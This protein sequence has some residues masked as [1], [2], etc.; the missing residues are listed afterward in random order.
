MDTESAFM[1]GMMNQHRTQMVFDWIKAAQIIRDEKPSHV[2]AGLAGDWEWTGGTIWSDGEV[3]EESYTYLASTWATPQIKV[4]G[5]LR[6]CFVMADETTWNSDTKW[7]DE[8]LA[9]LESK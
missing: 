6:P 3:D 9:I 5:V 7:P 4:D 8:A 1:N 2:G